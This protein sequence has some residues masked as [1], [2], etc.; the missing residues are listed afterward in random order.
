MAQSLETSP[1]P[2]RRG[3][4]TAANWERDQKAWNLPRP[5]PVDTV[6]PGTAAEGLDWENFV[7]TYFPRSRRHNL[8]ALV[9]YSDYKRSVRSSDEHASGATARAEAPSVDATSVE[10]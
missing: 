8:E 4:S 7:A 1:T 3:S 10:A 2:V 6:S 5:M 9:A